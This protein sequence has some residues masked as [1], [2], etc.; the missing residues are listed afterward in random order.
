MN[1]NT[2]PAGKLPV[3]SEALERELL[4]MGWDSDG[5][6]TWA[7]ACTTSTNCRS[8]RHPESGPV[9]PS[10]A[11]HRAVAPTFERWLR[12]AAAG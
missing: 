10:P 12:V 2:N 11:V 9:R 1:N 8:Q 4:E 6:L 7:D 3:D 5:F